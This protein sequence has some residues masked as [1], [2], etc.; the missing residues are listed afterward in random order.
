MDSSGKDNGA[1]VVD[2]YVDYDDDKVVAGN[3]QLETGPVVQMT[4]AEDPNEKT[5]E[6][7]TVKLTTVISSKK[8]GK[9]PKSVTQS[10]IENI[11]QDVDYQSDAAAEHYLPGV[12][13]ARQTNIPTTK[14]PI[15][16]G[17]VYTPWGPI[18]AGKLIAG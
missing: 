8:T 12:K 17:V 18:S 11:P 5:T 13:F 7:T 6:K 1:P 2:D 9:S 15:E 3:G 16:T 10:L 4:N 14:Q